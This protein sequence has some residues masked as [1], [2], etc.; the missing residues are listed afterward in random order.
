MKNV[1]LIIILLLSSITFGQNKKEQIE[2]LNLRIDSLKN[3]L[4]LS[5]EQ[6]NLL[7]NQT[8]SLKKV[9]IS[10]KDLSENKLKIALNKLDLQELDISELK[11]E[12][13]NNSTL[14][15]KLE[16]QL[17][18]KNDSLVNL[19]KLK[20]KYEIVEDS[21]IF[22]FSGVES[23]LYVFQKINIPSDRVLEK[24][25]NEAIYTLFNLTFLNYPFDPIHGF[26]LKNIPSSFKS[27]SSDNFK[28][29][30]KGGIDLFWYKLIFDHEGTFYIQL[31]NW[32]F[33]VYSICLE[34]ER[35]VPGEVNFYGR[36]LDDPN[37]E[38]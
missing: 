20:P 36:W 7:Y 3:I 24:K 34:E 13:N 37:R 11:K 26:N 22:K 21:I 32:D 31:N 27:M 30:D 5:K 9:L 23:E 12:T 2:I 1:Y 6:I 38:H 10:E 33:L 25:I 28:G 14:I 17:K 18:N 29:T 16:T 19:I 35:G 8:D 4:Q 15:G